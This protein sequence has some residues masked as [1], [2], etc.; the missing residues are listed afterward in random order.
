MI[1]AHATGDAA[2]IQNTSFADAIHPWEVLEPRYRRDYEYDTKASCHHV[3]Q[4]LHLGIT[5]VAA[6]LD[7]TL[8]TSVAPSHHII[9]AHQRAVWGN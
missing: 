8:C 1:H 4:S 9:T 3:V 6:L 7:W 2:K 5:S